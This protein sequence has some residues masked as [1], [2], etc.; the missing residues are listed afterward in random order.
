[1]NTR[2]LT[3]SKVLKI[4]GNIV[5]YL[6]L[7]LL[8]TFSFATMKLKSANDIASIFGR[9]FM[10]VL[11]PS[12]DGDREDSFTTED[13]IFVRIFEDKDPDAINEGDIV[14]FYKLDL[15]DDAPGTTPGFVT[16]RVHDTLIVDGNKYFITKGDANAEADSIA[17]SVDDILAV[18]TSKW[19]GAGNVLKYL[20]TSTGFAL[21]VI[22]PV[23][24]MFMIQGVFLVRNIIRLNKEKVVEHLESEKEAQLKALEAEKENMRQQILEE[25]KAQQEKKS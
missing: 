13:I 25:L 8:I 11:T 3:T 21:A 17:L 14:V 16:H 4:V 9:G 2:R 10:T 23:A 6:L 20:Q 5:F 7:A 18:Y 24:L 15:N 1:M 22:I 12:M 19:V